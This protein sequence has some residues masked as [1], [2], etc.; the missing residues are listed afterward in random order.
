MRHLILLIS[1]IFMALQAKSQSSAYSADSHGCG[2]DAHHQY[3]LKTDE[4]YKAGFLKQKA[5][6][7]SLKHAPVVR[8]RTS[9][10]LTIPV[11]VHVIHLGDPIGVRS[12]ISDDQIYGAIQGL[13]ERYANFNEQGIDIEMSFCLATRDPNGCP[14]SGI[15]RVDGSGI[16]GYAEDGVTWDGSCGVDEREVKDLSKWPTWEYYNIWVV[17]DICGSIAGYAY[18]PN[19]NEYDGTVIDIVSMTYENGTLAHE[20][21]HG[22]NLKHTF[23]GDDDGNCPANDDCLEDGD[24]VCDTPPHRTSFCGANN[25]CSNE[26]EWS[27]SRYNWMSY[28]FAAAEDGRFTEGQRTRVWDAMSVDPRASLLSSD[29]CANEIPMRITSDGSILCPDE[30]R[31]L[32]AQ[33]DGGYFV[34]ARGSGTIEGNILTASGGSEISIAYIIEEENCTATVVQDI[35]V[36]VVPNSLLKSGEDSLCI[37]QSTSL[38]GFPSGGEFFVISGPGSIDSNLLV[39]DGKGAITLLYEKSYLGCVLRDTHVVASFEEPV[40]EIELLADDILAVTREAE[41][42]QWVYC[43]QDYQEVQGATG[44]FLQVPSSGSYAIISINGMCRDTSACMQVLLSAVHPGGAVQDIR[45]YPN[46]AQDVLYL[47]SDISFE[48]VQIQMTDMRGITFAPTYRQH[49]GLL[50]LDLSSLLSGVYTVQVRL[51][52]GNREIFK[53][54]KL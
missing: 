28:C 40:A 6:L 29:G 2:T 11:V 18:Y 47:K 34:I 50:E 31:T 15:N 27:N 21:G 52:R 36:K 17:H 43:D 22:M 25:P 37:G 46:P 13:N 19:G 51:Y 53:V 48:K 5:T 30:P 20:L 44:D 8:P 24:E 45:V 26:G 4:E 14:T 12:N 1:L 42:F 23:S 35:P 39:A 9:Q 49:N 7:D 33:P 16:P 54:V 3:L 10:V 32:S 41:S 38:Q